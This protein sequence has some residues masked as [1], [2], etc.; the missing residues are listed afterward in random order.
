MRCLLID[1]VLEARTAGL[2]PP[3]KVA[4][5]QFFAS[6]SLY[7]WGLTYVLMRQ[8]LRVGLHKFAKEGLCC[9][10][11]SCTANEYQQVYQSFPRY[12]MRFLQGSGSYQGVSVGL[13]LGLGLGL[14]GG[15]RIKHKAFFRSH[16]RLEFW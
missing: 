12:A 7:G 9:V 5:A 10:A 2:G 16:I 8:R 11:E 4:L 1:L 15:L 3:E 13:G 6:R 14:Q